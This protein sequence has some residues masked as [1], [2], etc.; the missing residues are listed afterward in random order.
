VSEIPKKRQREFDDLKKALGIGDEEALA[1][2]T[3]NKTPSTI[4]DDLSTILGQHVRENY[5]NPLNA[6]ENKKILESVPVEHV[7]LPENILGKY[8]LT[9]N[10]IYLP[11]A[12][13]EIPSRQMGTKIHEFGHA[14]EVL[15]KGV[16][17]AQPLEEVQ[18][19]FKGS[20]IENATEAFGKH[21]KAGFYE[22]E[23]LKKLLKGG[24]LAISGL[25]PIAKALPVAGTVYGMSQGD[26]FAADPTGML[27]TDELGKGSDETKDKEQFD[28][29]PYKTLKNKLSK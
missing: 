27:Q 23:A 2:I 29:S 10:K 15:T 17:Y 18:K 21:H 9:E 3:R 25:A 11:H 7:K 28:F 12:N 16:K 24:K 4:K 20:G 22:L 19:L 13:L 5:D 14:D 8:S 6:F 26:A 1:D